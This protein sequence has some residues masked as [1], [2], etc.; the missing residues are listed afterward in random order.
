[1]ILLSSRILKFTG[2]LFLSP[3]VRRPSGRQNSNSK[4]SSS[5]FRRRRRSLQSPGRNSRS[6]SPEDE[7]QAPELLSQCIS[8]LHSVI[9]E[10]CRYQISSP[11]LLRPPNALQAVSLDVTQLLIHMHTDSPKVLSQIGF[12][13]LPAFSTYRNEMHGRLLRFFE[14]GVLR[15]MLAQARQL[16]GFGD[17]SSAEKKGIFLPLLAH[18]FLTSFHN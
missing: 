14:E 1:M 13:I 5:P 12:A 2:L 9:S 18:R 11:R 16:Q 17:M 4:S 15:G 3:S 8:I 6:P 10:D 7:H